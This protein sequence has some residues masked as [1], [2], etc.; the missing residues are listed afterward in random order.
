MSTDQRATEK[1]GEL[2][3]HVFESLLQVNTD[4]ERLQDLL[5]LGIDLKQLLAPHSHMT[6]RFIAPQEERFR[7]SWKKFVSA[8]QDAEPNPSQ[9]R[10]VVVET[11]DPA[12]APLPAAMV[13]AVEKPAPAA[14]AEVWNVFGSVFSLLTFPAEHSQP[15]T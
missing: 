12:P 7:E 4:F 10:S 2:I 3:H 9:P 8:M 15:C 11:V 5:G 6:W 1:V 13:Q 14:Q